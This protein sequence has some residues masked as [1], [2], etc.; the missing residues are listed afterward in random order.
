[1]K[2]LFQKLDS[3]QQKT[4]TSE[5]RAADEISHVT[6]SVFYLEA[7]VVLWYNTG[8]PKHDLAQETGIEFQGY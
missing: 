2:L 7:L 6:D 1:M 3:K 5:K 4:V 8:G